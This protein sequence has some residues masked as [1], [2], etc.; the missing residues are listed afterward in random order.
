M[1]SYSTV[2]RQVTILKMFAKLYKNAQLTYR[3]KERVLRFE[4]NNE[5]FDFLFDE[6]FQSL[7]MGV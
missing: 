7:Y 2:Q 4:L 6:T 5:E 3:E 1:K